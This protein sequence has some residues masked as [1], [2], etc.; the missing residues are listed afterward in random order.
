MFRLDRLRSMGDLSNWETLESHQLA[1]HNVVASLCALGI[2]DDFSDDSA[3]HIVADMLVVHKISN[4]LGIA[5]YVLDFWFKRLTTLPGPLDEDLLS[6]DNF[7]VYLPAQ[8]K[9]VAFLL[10][11]AKIE[12]SLAFEFGLKLNTIND[13]Y[14]VSVLVSSLEHW[15]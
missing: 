1:L 13:Y 7:E 6:R 2:F 8:V 4:I 15:L 10:K 9:N 5:L 11:A 3:I 14:F 12:V